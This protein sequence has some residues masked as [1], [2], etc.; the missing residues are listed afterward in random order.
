MNFQTL[1]DLWSPF[2]TLDS[3]QIYF[4]GTLFLSF[5][6]TYGSLTRFYEWFSGSGL[7]MADHRGWGQTACKFYGIFEA[8][9][10]TLA[11]MRG[12]GAVLVALMACIPCVVLCKI[13]GHFAEQNGLVSEAAIASPVPY[14]L[15]ALCY[16]AALLL[17]HLYLSQVYC[18]AHVGAHVTVLIP[19]TMILLAL[20]NVGCLEMTMNS[21]PE[22]IH[23]GLQELDL[24]F[25]FYLK[26]LL[27]TVYSMAGLSKLQESWK[28]GRSWMDGATLQTTLLE[29]IWLS[30]S[31]PGSSPAQAEAR[32]GYALPHFTFGLPTPYSDKVQIWAIK[33]PLVLTI[34]SVAAVVIEA[35]APVV[36]L[37][38]CGILPGWTSFA[39]GVLGFG[40]HFGILYLQNVDFLSWW[41]P[42]YVFFFDPLMQKNVD[43][44][45]LLQH[46]VFPI[47]FFLASFYAV[48]HLGWLLIL[49]TCGGPFCLPLSPFR[50]FCD[51]RDFFHPDSQK[52][53][54]LSDK[55]HATGT[56]KNYAFPIAC[57]QYVRPE[58]LNQVD[59]KYLGVKYGPTVA[60]VFNSGSD[61]KEP[62]LQDTESGRTE[63]LSCP[64]RMYTNLAMSP[65]LEQGLDRLELI[66][67]K[68][69]GAWKNPD[70]IDEML[71][72]VKA[73][74][75]AFA[76]A[77]RQSAKEGLAD[78]DRQ[79]TGSED[80]HVPQSET[81]GSASQEGVTSTQ[82]MS[83]PARSAQTASVNQDALVG[84]RILR[85]VLR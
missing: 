46:E 1:V 6:R 21:E 25:S 48:W 43:P 77:S 36:L 26:V 76:E 16:A 39:F 24:L 30:W 34:S 50:M 33:S 60:R 7:A 18:E 27:C 74:K 10:L 52:V 38:Q 49:K 17:Y 83:A 42:C 37:N 82:E 51:V 19:P 12:A 45:L 11:E 80:T 13:F 85:T 69:D 71:D 23:R 2:C 64:R 40:L 79:S 28:R 29:A 56:L 14:A 70:A 58:E 75:A 61:L 59:F 47:T 4:C 73:L 44:S 31:P 63:A 8:P 72:C 62:L 78:A 22:R 65:A 55:P 68:G 35:A 15:L 81:S 54:W 84:A 5:A 41:L 9:K 20:Y 53:F 57:E 3:F 66:G 32:N 67:R